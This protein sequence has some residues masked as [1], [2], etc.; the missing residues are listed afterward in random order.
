MV[1]SFNNIVGCDNKL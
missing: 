1:D